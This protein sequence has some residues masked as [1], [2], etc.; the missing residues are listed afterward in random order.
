MLLP[1][2]TIRPV[3]NQVERHPLLPRWELLDFCAKKDI[4][5]QAHTLL[6]QG[7]GDLLEHALVQQLAVKLKCSPTQ[8]V[9][10]WNLQ[11]G[12]AVVPKCSSEV[13]MQ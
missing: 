2:C 4:L 10:W 5:L 3:A 12:V 1:H 6:G 11:Q 7:H 8:V 9:L 13:H